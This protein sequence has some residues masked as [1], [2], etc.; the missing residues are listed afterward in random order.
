M[1]TDESRLKDKFIVTI[2]LFILYLL[3]EYSFESIISV[4]YEYMIHLPVS[5]DILRVMTGFIMLFVILALNMFLKV[6]PF[7]F[8]INT[9]F[10]ILLFIPTI[11][12]YISTTEF[13]TDLTLI[14]FFFILL[15]ILSGTIKIKQ[16]L[17]I[18]VLK[19]KTKAWILFAIAFVLLIPFLVTFK[20]NIHPEL[21]LLKNVYKVRTQI[22]PHYTSMHSYSLSWIS[23]IL[24]PLLIITGTISK[25]KSFILIGIGILLYLYLVTGFKSIFFSVF[26]IAPLLFVKD[27]Y[28]QTIIIAF[29]FV[30]IIAAS[31]IIYLAAGQIVPLS[32]F[33]RRLLILPSALNNAYFNLFQDMHMHLSHSIFSS[34]FECPI[35]INPT[36]YVCQ[37]A[38]GQS[39]KANTG[40]LADGFMNFGYAGVAVYA[41]I[42]ILIFMYF[43]NQNTNAKYAGLFFLVIFTMVSSALLTTLLNHGVI[44]LMILSLFIMRNTD[45][46]K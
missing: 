24:I 14:T 29:I 13:R 16:T 43:N 9:V 38:M 40:F 27:Y 25:K 18:P 28:K 39:C 3:L 35:D 1:T 20:A 10:I 12:L 22:A 5:H 6:S 41:A 17:K 45:R 19:N 31:L 34:L 44:L 2:L 36:V 32:L 8:F 15:L 30:G 37:H 7:S 26:L 11:T 42:V 4:K 21:L 46:I 23:K 33:A